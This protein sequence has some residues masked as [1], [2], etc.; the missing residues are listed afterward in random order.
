MDL[1]GDVA[2]VGSPKDAGD[3]AKSPRVFREGALPP[4][5]VHAV[6][7]NEVATAKERIDELRREV[8]RT[9][10]GS[11]PACRQKPTS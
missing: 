8:A 11:S 5:F 9:Y 4:R 1:F 10:I 7:T 3:P 6:A 2:H